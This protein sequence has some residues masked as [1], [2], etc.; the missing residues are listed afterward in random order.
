MCAKYKVWGGYQV[1]WVVQC[2]LGWFGVFPRS[3]NFAIYNHNYCL[4]SFFPAQQQ[5]QQLKVKNSYKATIK[6]L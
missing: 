1:V 3:A 4:I 6:S 2:V 5:S